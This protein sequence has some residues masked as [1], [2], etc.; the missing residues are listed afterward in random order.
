MTLIEMQQ[1]L[2][3]KK[4]RLLA[5]GKL[6]KQKEI[7]EGQL[8]HAE[9]DIKKYEQSLKEARDRFNKLDNFSFINLFRTWTGRQ[10][11]LVE[12]GYDRMAEME[13]KLIESQLIFEDLNKEAIAL[14]NKIGEIQEEDVVEH[15]KSLEMKIQIYY[16]ANDPQMAD[17]LNDVTEQ[18]LLANQLIIEIDEALE[19]GRKAQQKLTEAAST[20]HTASGYSTW[21]TFFGGGV[22][23]TALKHQELDKT[24]SHIHDAQQALQR[25]QN[26][27]LDIQQMRH[28]TLQIEADGFVKFADFFFDDLFS[29]WSI[30]S[31]IATSTN[32]I[33][34]VSDDVA[35][36]LN[37]LKKKR[38]LAEEKKK[39]LVDE[40]SQLISNS[41]KDCVNK[42]TGVK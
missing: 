4:G 29:A 9:A 41:G 42:T 24:N 33:R 25:F 21:D 3:E 36:T 1:K 8:L 18:E 10:D 32:Q 37:E 7:V 38:A 13:L 19:A 34:R 28:G 23:A 16:M 40:K 22:I 11:E 26:E 39:Q 6:K 15:I 30:H 35:N 20:L 2:Q 12:E 5:L 31:K 27:L 14:Q 17:R